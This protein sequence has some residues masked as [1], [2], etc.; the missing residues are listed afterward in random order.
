MLLC[1][2]FYS[3][4]ILDAQRLLKFMADLGGCRGH[5]CLLIAD[6]YVDW[7]QAIECV[8][9]AEICFDSVQIIC[10]GEHAKGQFEGGNSK[11]KAAAM[12]AQEHG[13]DFLFNEPD[14]IPLKTGWLDTIESAW[15]IESQKTNVFFLGA[16]IQHE[17]P[18]FPNF[19][20][21]GNA[22]YHKNT[23]SEISLIWDDSVT[24]PKQLHP[25]FSGRSVSSKLF[26]HVFGEVGNPPVFAEKNVAGTSVFSLKNIPVEAVVFH[27]S[28]G[29]SL[30]RQLQRARG[31]SQPMTIIFPIFPADVQLATT[32]ARWLAQMGKQYPNL[33]K[34]VF[35]ATI[36]ISQ[37]T[38]FR[39]ELQKTFPHIELFKY[40]VP[41]V[42]GWP[43]A[44][45]FAFQQVARH[46]AQQENPWLWFE[47]DCVALKPDWLERIEDEYY[48][49]GRSWMG[50]IVKGM[51]HVNGVCVYPP[52]AALRSPTAMSCTT[53][54]WD[55]G[56]RAEMI[57]DCHDSS[58]LTGH[59]WSILNGEAIETGGGETPNRVTLEQARK[60][61]KPSWVIVHRIKSSDLVNLLSRGEFKP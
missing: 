28:K 29:G 41:P 2:P 17:T 23:W 16:I 45:N 25:I 47:A 30:I 31:I 19:Y 26:F 50:P 15:D 57:H 9:L 14:N 13:E 3:G 56:M 52:D 20:L 58:D 10:D 21:E 51:G 37:L 53:V 27:R 11:F 1:L 40:P 4:D 8:K 35:D 34:I 38:A 33:A 6:K 36:N 43:M 12:W 22:V 60:W 7:V 59:I 48:M 5:S 18:N 44:P 49:S 46:M 54:A 42:M 24:W 39:N 55:Y 61:I 32:H